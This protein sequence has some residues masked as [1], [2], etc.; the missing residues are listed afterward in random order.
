VMASLERMRFLNAVIK[1]EG[2]DLEDAS[3]YGEYKQL[4][5]DMV[6]TF[7]PVV[8]LLVKAGLLTST[9][10]IEDIED[11]HKF[12]TLDGEPT[13]AFD[14]GNIWIDTEFAGG[15]LRKSGES[16]PVPKPEHFTRKWGCYVFDG[17]KELYCPGCYT[18]GKKSPTTR[19][20]S[21]FRQCT[22]C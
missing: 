10:N 6:T 19:L 3:I 7:L 15:N 18:Q 1:S 13:A 22:V 12:T 2:D 20:S 21:R 16:Q 11:I 9:I 14:N 5:G 4:L 8:K 17:D